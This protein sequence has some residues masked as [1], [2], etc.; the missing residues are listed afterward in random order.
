MT[1]KD[2]GLLS[3]ACALRCPK[4]RLLQ[5]D[6]GLGLQGVGCPNAAAIRHLPMLACWCAAAMGLHKWYK[7]TPP[8]SCH[9]HAA[10][11]PIKEHSRSD[12]QLNQVVGLSGSAAATHGW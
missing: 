9:A 8:S 3:R 12:G 6:L 4:S 7:A 11:Q 5:T 2:A 10:L 1:C